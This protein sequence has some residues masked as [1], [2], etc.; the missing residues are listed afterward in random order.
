MRALL[1]AVCL[2]I[3][4]AAGAHAATVTVPDETG[5]IISGPEISDIVEANVAF[6]PKRLSISV[7]HGDWR[8]EWGRKRAA[9]GGVV[10]FGNGRSFV[11]IP[12]MTARRS[13]LYTRKDFGNCQNGTSCALPCDGWRYQVDQ[14]ARTTQVSVPVR[15]FGTRSA[16]VK[17]RALHMV[18]QYGQQTVVDP[19]ATSPW[20]A[21]G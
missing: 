3:A 4:T 11:I 8:W 17:V 12:N 13:L 16:R 14:Q 19:V 9:T 7:T 5:D 18:P 15:C 10:T 21:R 20:I 1:A 6:S 2:L